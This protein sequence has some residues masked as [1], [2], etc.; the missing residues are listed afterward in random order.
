MKISTKYI[1][2]VLLLC[3]IGAFCYGTYSK[4]QLAS[5]I[6]VIDIDSVSAYNMMDS[7][8]L[9]QSDRLSYAVGVCASEGFI[10][11][12]DS[13]YDLTKQTLPYF[14]AG[15]L[16]KSINDSTD[17]E[18]SH[19]G[20][21]G[22]GFQ[23]YNVTKRSGDDLNL[24]SKPEYF[25]ALSEGFIASKPISEDESLKLFEMYNSVKEKNARKKYEENRRRSE[26]FIARK[27]KESGVNRLPGGTLY[28][29]IKAGNGRI[30][31]EKQT[32]SIKYTGKLMDGTVFDTTNGK[33]A[34]ELKAYQLIHGLSE[35]LTHM[36]VGSTWEIYIP[37][38]QAYDY[39]EQ[40]SVKPY[41]ALI[42]IVTLV[43]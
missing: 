35:A 16:G 29:V 25:K 36:K 26:Q 33:G 34:V 41:S 20:G 30:P 38:E 31:S 17:M 9:S 8:N 7:F 11:Y 1:T 5:P 39:R 42:F 43:K 22:I 18:K 2:M 32:I 14:I 10:Q 6:S 27:A 40:G 19:I 15:F 3:V 24:K 4:H 37:Y 23:L 28:K 12:V 21:I 13:M